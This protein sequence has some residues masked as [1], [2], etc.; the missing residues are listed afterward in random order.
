MK[1]SDLKQMKQIIA[2]VLLLFLGSA[3]VASQTK[4]SAQQQQ[5]VLQKFNGHA[6][7]MKTM[8]CDFVQTKKMKLMKNELR[9]QGVMFY[10]RPNK[11]RWQYDTP[12]SYVFVLNGDKVTMKSKNNTQQ[13]DVQRNKMFRQISDL[14]LNS[15]TGGHLQ[16]SSD[17]DVEIWKTADGYSAQL[18]PKKKELKK[19]YKQ[20]GIVLDASCSMMKRIT[21]EEKSGDVTTVILSH[22]KTNQPIS[23]SQFTIR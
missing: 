11:L 20:I 14:I 18:T 7:S 23:E 5:Q 3:P 4:L 2:F 15:V 8:Q 12:Y 13:V 9:S 17:F 16:S 6:A 21:M 19:L 10:A 1:T 22:V